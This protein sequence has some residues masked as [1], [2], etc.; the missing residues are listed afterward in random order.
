MNLVY[1]KKLILNLVYKN[2]QPIIKTTVPNNSSKQQFQT[3]VPNNS[4][5]FNQNGNC[6][7]HPNCCYQHTG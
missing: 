3:T 5:I 7:P 6:F 2:R 4:S 1:R